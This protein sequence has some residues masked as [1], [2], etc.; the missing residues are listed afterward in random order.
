[1]LDL[2]K[3]YFACAYTAISFFCYVFFSVLFA[4]CRPYLLPYLAITALVATVAGFVDMLSIHSFWTGAWFGLYWCAFI[5][6]ILAIVG[7]FSFFG[8]FPNG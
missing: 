7:T 4:V 6:C 3:L 2:L 5:G 1:M 8:R